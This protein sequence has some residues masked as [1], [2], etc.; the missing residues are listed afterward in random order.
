MAAWCTSA[1]AASVDG[2]AVEPGLIDPT[3]P[4][5]WSSPDHAGNTMGYWPAYNDIDPHARAAYLSWLADGRRHPSAY[6][7]FVFL[8]FY[9]LE[10]RLL[11]DL[12][13]GLEGDE[14]GELLNE[15]RRLV[16]VYGDNGS[17]R[18][19]ASDL[20]EFCDA[21]RS[22]HANLEPPTW[23]PSFRDW[24][25]PTDIRVAIGR[26]V[27]AGQPIPDVWA[28]TYLRHHP[29][30]YLRTPAQRCVS[31]FDEL[32]KIRYR[33][34]YGDGLKVRPPAARLSFSYRAASGGINRDVHAQIDIPDVASISGPINKLTELAA[35]VTDELDA[36]SRFLGRRP[37]E[38]AT[39]SAVALLPDELLDGHAS[40]VVSALRAWTDDRL[41][42]QQSATVDAT[43]LLTQW[44]PDP[45]ARFVKRDAV[46]LS[47]MLAKLGVGVEP[48]VRFGAATPKP[49]ESAVLFR[50]PP[51]SAAAPSPAYTAAMSL[52]HLTA[53]VAAADGSISDSE[54]AQLG[55]HA[56]HVLGLD[57]GEC[58]RLEA[59]LRF[60]G[61]GKLTMAGSKKKVE[62]LAA[63]QRAAVGRFLVDVAAADGV[64]SPEEITT[65]TKVFKQLGLEEASVYSQ[66]HALEAGDTGPITVRQ[67][68][69]TQRWQLPEG[70]A[71][72]EGAGVVLDPA[73][74]QARLAETARVAAL[75]TG[76]F[77][78]EDQGEPGRP[79]PSLATNAA[80]P[81]F[82]PPSGSA[83]DL[84]PPQSST[85][86]T[87]VGGSPPTAAAPEG[88]AFAGLDAAHSTLALRL[89]ERES[90]SRADAE[91]A[92]DECGLPFLDAALD[93]I[94]DATFEICGEPLVE[95]DDPV[96]LNAF[97]L[98]EMTR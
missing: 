30:A 75:L 50:L 61:E 94:N 7:G 92:A 40:G 67:A 54:Q 60:L 93:R 62:A 28:L 38:S 23:D 74:V 26:Y 29:E 43:D 95:G 69:Q 35:E 1:R 77:A 39:L 18:R 4:V 83:A 76:I 32:F 91:D 63:D 8:F 34:R 80:A 33:K 96:E 78:D 5:A 3:L 52:V 66:V 73:K 98:E 47:S 25:I 64:I 51:D 88:N 56:E 13:D 17:F 45:A 21:G 82:A 19:Y 53:V 87:A 31:E 97:A 72:V 79:S 20:L 48:D 84:P 41:D 37:D 42:G 10:R 71:E 70:G 57:P 2:T 46:A 12:D 15:V 36:Y 9:G 24:R 68:Q 85:A 65:L 22:I 90:W 59:H 81:G 58:V 55:E 16:A 27:A 44:S 49:G 11:F 86:S 6:I 14:A 89:A